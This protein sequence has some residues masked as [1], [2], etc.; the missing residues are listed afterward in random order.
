M[1][2]F[3]AVNAIVVAAACAPAVVKPGPVRQ[4]LDWP[5]YLGSA[6]HDAAATETLNQDPRSL[7]RATMHRGVRG[8]PAIG[9][10][11]L[12][13]G[14]ADRH[15]VLIDRASGETLW[16]RRLDGTVRA[17]PLLDDDRLYVA[18]EAQPDGRV[19]AIRLR[20]GE[21]LWRTRSGSVAAPLAYDGDALYAAT[22]EGTVARLDPETGSVVWR[23]ELP[24][25]GAI[26]AAPVPT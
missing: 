6:R 5:A 13:V 11:I 18:T 20:D 24:A 17:G 12:A 7:W 2:G 26:R 4:E 1:A 25:E 15:L 16:R 23:R 9:E 8:S 10:T 14:T 19:Y 21:R 22:E 3:G